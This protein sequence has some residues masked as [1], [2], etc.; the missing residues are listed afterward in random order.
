M[1]Q[2]VSN[3]AL[4]EKLKEMD[5]KLNELSMMQKSV[6]PKQDQAEI[7]LDFSE[8]KDGIIAKIKEEASL[9][10]THSDVNFGTVN[11]NIE[12]LHGSIGKVFNIVSRIRKQQKESVEPRTGSKDRYFNFKLFKVRKTSLVITALALLVFLLTLF[13]MK[14]QNDYA[15]LMDK[16]YRQ[17]NTIHKLHEAKQLEKEVEVVKAK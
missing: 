6:D 7:K 11:K 10:G 1:G 8:V 5:K 12:L 14:Q 13:C 3:D 4:L 2:S 9:L 16:Y 15:L 17:S